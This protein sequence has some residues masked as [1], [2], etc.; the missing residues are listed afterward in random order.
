MEYYNNQYDKL[1]N[2]IVNFAEIG[3]IWIEI[4]DT[5]GK[6]FVSNTGNVLSLY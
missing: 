1:Y 4:P 6:Y 5:D 3:D 2:F